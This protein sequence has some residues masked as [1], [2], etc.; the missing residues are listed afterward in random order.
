MPREAQV[1]PGIHADPERGSEA[2]TSASSA[3][4]CHWC[5]GAISGRRRNGFCSDRCRMRAR[6]AER[7]VR[8]EGLLADIDEAVAALRAEL[9]RGGHDQREVEQREAISGGRP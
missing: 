3:A 6:R 1:M 7:A 4:S 5:G 2:R 8:V 9:R